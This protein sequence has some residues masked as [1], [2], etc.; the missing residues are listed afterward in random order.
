[1]ILRVV[2][3]TSTLVGA[4]FRP[5]SVPDRALRRVLD[6]LQLCVC[7]ELLA[8]LQNALSKP[9]LGRYITAEARQSFLDMLRR[10]GE[11]YAIGES[12]LACVDPP[13]RDAND[14]FILALALAARA[15]AI[16]SRDHDL[17]VLNPWRGIPV[18]PPAEFVIQLSA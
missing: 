6:S 10:N 2:F 1:M 7:V 13:C 4:I 8:E 14:N 11:S 18:L 12:E 5:D 3:D 15:H 17:L 9:R 16:L